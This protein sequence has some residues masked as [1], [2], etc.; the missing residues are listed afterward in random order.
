MSKLWKGFACGLALVAVGI[1]A[2]ACPKK[3]KPKGG[4]DAVT[5]T[6]TTSTVPDV[7]FPPNTTSNDTTVAPPKDFVNDTPVVRTEDLPLDIEE[8]NRVAQQRGYIQDAF[9]G[10]D[11]ATLSTEAQNALSASATWL[12]S[13]P[14]YN[15]LVEGHCD[16]RGTEQYNLALGDRRANQVKDYLSALGVDA[17]RMRTVS[18]GEERPFDPGHDESS[19]SKNRRAHLVLVGNR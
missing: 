1:L 5:Q 12:K 9:F 19:W 7:N 10:Y 17:S 18:Y 13:N 14:K 6:Q 3:P 15:L 16:E 4:G 8:A 2:T 11:E